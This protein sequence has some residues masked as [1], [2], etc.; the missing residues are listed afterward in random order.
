MKG[1]APSMPAPGMGTGVAV[2][3]G[4]THGGGGPDAWPPLRPPP[5]GRLGPPQGLPQGPPQGPPQKPPQGPTHGPPQHPHPQAHGGGGA[6]AWPPMAPSLHARQGPH[7][8]PHQEPSPGPTQG[9]PLHPYLKAHGEGGAGAWLPM[10]PPPHVRQGPHHGPHQG[11]HQGPNQAPYQGPP[12]HPHYGPHGSTWEPWP[13]YLHPHGAA[14]RAPLPPPPP[15]AAHGSAA[16]APPPR[17]RAPATFPPPS[18]QLPGSFPS[19]SPQPAPRSHPRWLI[20]GAALLRLHADVLSSPASVAAAL[21]QCAELRLGTIDVDLGIYNMASPRLA[22]Q[23]GHSWTAQLG[24]PGGLLPALQACRFRQTT[25]VNEG[26]ETVLIA[27][28]SVLP[29]RAGSLLVLDDHGV[30]QPSTA[31]LLSTAHNDA[32]EADASGRVVVQLLPGQQYSATLALNL[33]TEAASANELGILSSFVLFTVLVPPPPSKTGAASGGTATADRHA[34]ASGS[35]PSAFGLHAAQAGGDGGGGG[36]RR[37]PASGALQPGSGASG[38]GGGPASSPANPAGGGSGSGGES[39]VVVAMCRASVALL[40]EA[41]VRR[42]NFSARPFVPEAILRMFET[43]P[44]QLFPLPVCGLEFFLRPDGRPTTDLGLGHHMPPGTRLLPNCP[45]VSAAEQHHWG[46]ARSHQSWLRCIERHAYNAAQAHTHGQEAP[47]GGLPAGLEAHLHMLAAEEGAAEREAARGVQLNLRPRFGWVSPREE[48]VGLTTPGQSLQWLEMLMPPPN[49]ASIGIKKALDEWS[50]VCSALSS[51]SG[52][53]SSVTP[54]G[55]VDCHGEAVWAAAVHQW[56]GPKAS[57]VSAHQMNKSWRGLVVFE[58]PGLL[59]GRPTLLMGDLAY[60]RFADGGMGCGPRGVEYVGVVA[61]IQQSFALV[62]LPP[63]WWDQVRAYGVQMG[64]GGSGGGSGDQSSGARRV[65]PP[66]PKCHVRFGINRTPFQ[67][68][69][70]AVTRAA[71]CAPGLLKH[72]APKAAGGGGGGGGAGVGGAGMAEQVRSMAEHMVL[73]GRVQLNVEQRTAIAAVVCGV[74]QGSQDVASASGKAPGLSHA[75]KPFALFGPPGTGKTV[76]LVEVALQLMHALV[77]YPGEAYRRRP[78]LLLCAP[79][80]YSADL[81]CSAL[82]E[83]GV[84]PDAMARIQD[85]RRRPAETKADVTPYCLFDESSSCYRAP[86]A[87]DLA[88]KQVIVTSCLSAG[89]LDPA[90]L[91]GP[92]SHQFAKTWLPDI[93]LVDE[94]GQATVPEVLVP[95]ALAA[96][97]SGTLGPNSV[98]LCGDPYQLGPV[99]KSASARAAGLGVSLLELVLRE[100]QGGGGDLDGIPRTVMLRRNYRSHAQLL[101]LPSRMFYDGG[102]LPAADATAVATPDWHELSADHGDAG[103]A[104]AVLSGGVRLPSA[105]QLPGANDADVVAERAE[106]AARETAAAAGAGAEGKGGGDAAEDTGGGNCLFYGV[107]GVQVQESDAPSFH[108]PIEAAVLVDLVQSL[109]YPEATGRPVRDPRSRVNPSDVGVICTYRKQVAALRLMLREK[110]LGVVRVGTVDDFQGQEARVVFISTVLSSVE[111]LPKAAPE[112]AA[113]TAAS[114]AVEG[115][116][117]PVWGDV[118]WGSTRDGTWTAG[119]ECDDDG[120]GTAAAGSGATALT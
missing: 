71:F 9:P 13:P 50:D 17:D 80:N 116:H 56:R 104:A 112:P 105:S 65:A 45:A 119:G 44:T 76:T 46:A 120:G 20:S 18:A 34:R 48:G 30:A 94:A 24:V 74:Q 75:D 36:A 14:P 53:S 39:R 83:A 51:G 25:I 114:A 98:V 49:Q 117:A 26:R 22:A 42:L 81:I 32:A 97:G 6:S 67:R 43:A 54:D 38:S 1:A 99:V 96:A 12:P 102:L 52:G 15:A 77:Q 88:N 8:G 66:V 47:V 89:L 31:I 63:L 41:S 85:P 21:Q 11:P 58:A 64:G 91:A 115:A 40:R 113:E 55:V 16:H 86:V 35:A 60:V 59:E 62:Y 79:Q 33:A 37:G 118:T 93:V 108:N 82:A 107:R 92:E 29:D 95:V 27:A 111:Y 103:G 2:G 106:R 3:T 110:G 61:T 73:R 19:G 90:A 78:R 57:G 23:L 70:D 4:P 109:L 72:H 101:D 69:H 5:H 100:V 10:A 28:V 68:M 87:E 84:A 7:Q